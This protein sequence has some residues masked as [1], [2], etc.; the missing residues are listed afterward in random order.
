MN[1]L[2]PDGSAEGGPTAVEVSGLGRRYHRGWALKNCSFRIPAGRICALVGPNGAGK[3]T[4]MSLVAQLLAPTEGS[5]RVFGHPLGDLAVRGRIGFVAQDKP[6]YPGFTVAE[7]LRL[8]RELN[9]SW[10]QAKAESV[11]AQGKVPLT[12]RIGTLSG[13]QR[14]RVSMAL[15]LGAM[16]DLLILDEPMSDLDPLA[17]HQLM[18]LLMSEAA[19]RGITVL[20]SSH[21][22]AELEDSCDYLVLLSEGGVLLAGDIE[23][24]LAA[25]Q[26]LVGDDGAEAP[27]PDRVVEL[28]RT[29]RQI[30]ALVRTDGRAP[31]GWEVNHPT[32]EEVLLAHLRS[33]AVPAL[34]TAEARPADRT[35]AA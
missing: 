11:V 12:A 1:A 29:G 25:H 34:L 17:R 2:Y 31:A 16:P 7:T 6:L 13:G 10:D 19:E 30:T 23:E 3:T 35:V 22:I 14:T 9:R 28:N 32:L 5:V 15:A 20:M 26:L 8:G 18:G 27:A 33:G 24:I 4:L 21:V